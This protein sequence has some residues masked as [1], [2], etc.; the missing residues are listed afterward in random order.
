MRIDKY[1]WVTRLQKTRTV[2]TKAC[3]GNRVVVDGNFVKPSRAIA[4][5]DT[6]SLRRGAFWFDYR[7]IDIPKS[8]V[9]AK[10]VPDFV[11]DCTPEHV[12]EEIAK[13]SMMRTEHRDR[14]TGRPTKR[15]RRDIDD[16][17]EGLS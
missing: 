17:K 10:L 5:G 3:T 11:E 13:R 12:R 1:L 8:R 4:I 7:V 6:F 14:G 9:G 16:F 15:E 2:A